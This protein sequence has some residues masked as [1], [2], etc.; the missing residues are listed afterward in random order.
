MTA[1]ISRPIV[2]CNNYKLCCISTVDRTTVRLHNISIIVW[3]R[4]WLDVSPVHFLL[5]AWP[6]VANGLY[7]WAQL[8]SNGEKWSPQCENLG[9]S[10]Q[11]VCIRRTNDAF[12]SLDICVLE[13]E[14]FHGLLIAPTM[15]LKHSMYVSL[16]AD[17]NWARSST[18]YHIKCT[19]YLIWRLIAP[20]SLPMYL[21]PSEK[22][23]L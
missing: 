5:V 14:S 8:I 2:I 22:F 20:L 6:G 23:A 4:C 16:N 15:T 13:V 11:N 10:C 3:R 9:F 21:V 1:F 19:L 12:L 7:R 17:G 18:D